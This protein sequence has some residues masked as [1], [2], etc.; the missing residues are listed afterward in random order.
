MS[1][2][3]SVSLALA[4]AREGDVPSLQAWCAGGGD[5][6]AFD[7][8]GWT[9]LLWAA[10]RGQP[11][12]TRFLLDQGADAGLAHARSGALPLHLAGQSGSVECARMLLA[13]RPDLIDAVY[14]INAHTILLQ[15][16]FY[17]HLDLA[18]YVLEQGASTALTTA[19][20]LG[21]L[22]LAA[23]FQNEAMVA[24]IRPYDSPAEA[25]AAAYR[26]YLDQIRV[27]VAPGEEPLQAL[28]DQMVGA[29]EGGLK[30]AATDPGAVDATLATL[31]RLIETEGAPVNRLGGALGQP[32]LVV[33]VT[34]P[35]GFPANPN[36][37][38]LRLAVAE[39]LLDH[40]ADP[41]VHENH[42][43][44]AQ[45]VIRAAVFNHLDILKICARAVSPQA[46][47]DAINE[48]P[49]VNGLTAMH[50]TVLRATM[51]AP[52]RV[53][54]YLDQVRW[55]V[56]HGGRVDIED[57]AGLT[58]RAVAEQ[59]ADPDRRARLLEAMGE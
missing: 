42:P 54:G 14:R 45:T 20:G 7:G 32:P 53:D 57:F 52:D 43:M 37:A 58:Q 10:A 1:P 36:L 34:G 2:T 26:A 46:Y 40:G 55:F 22:E 11:A 27:P 38:R 18:R 6:N 3:P 39:L 47:T 29:I 17:G 28:A 12:T 5:P 31:R 41:T 23:Q 25:K 44:G 35:N 50:D 4:A 19:R 9:P 51:A 16:V 15:A 59:A 21:P 24:V 48:I 56:S 49:L 30:A 33:A 8:E 13:A